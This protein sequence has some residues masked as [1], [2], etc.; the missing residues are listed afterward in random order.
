MLCLSILNNVFAD[1][2]NGGNRIKIYTN[3]PSIIKLLFNFAEVISYENKLPI[4]IGI[5]EKNKIKSNILAGRIDILVTD[6]YVF[7]KELEAFEI[8]T[9]EGFYDRLIYISSKDND[10]VKK[11]T[12][13][14][15]TS[16]EDK[17]IFDNS[18][19]LIPSIFVSSLNLCKQIGFMIELYEPSF[20]KIIIKESVAKK[21][22]LKFQTA[23][24]N[25][26]NLYY[27]VAIN[28]K[29]DRNLQKIV[30]TFQ[31]SEKIKQIIK[32]N[33]YRN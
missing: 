24:D 14:L 22:N 6:D 33:G 10:K 13:F 1:G 32:E 25:L 17:D 27:I 18:A 4:S 2:G 31:A 28:G 16:K 21:C 8:T 29:D 26:Y 5:E 7:I 30:D 23:F 15:K 12:L 9:F 3:N 19:K 11:P 20:E